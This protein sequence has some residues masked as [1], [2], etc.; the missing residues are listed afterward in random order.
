MDYIDPHDFF[1]GR[2][3]L[4]CLPNQDLGDLIGARVV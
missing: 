3:R 2:G 1:A 4:N